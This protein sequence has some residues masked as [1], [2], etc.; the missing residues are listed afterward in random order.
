MLAQ[1]HSM[2]MERPAAS[3]AS[4]EE[5][6]KANVFL[7]GESDVVGHLM[8]TQQDDQLI[9]QGRVKGLKPGKHGFHVH[10]YGDIFTDGC[11]STGTHFNPNGVIRF[12]SILNQNKLHFI[13]FF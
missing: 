10:Q 7:F 8:L 13:A 2:A 6:M 5:I 1:R 12:K 3:S 4:A 11:D 9:I